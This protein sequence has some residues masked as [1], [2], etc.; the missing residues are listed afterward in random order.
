MSIYSQIPTRW[1][2]TAGCRRE[3][4]G[5]CYHSVQVMDPE[6]MISTAHGRQG[7][8][9]RTGIVAGS[10]ASWRIFLTV[11]DM[12]LALCK[13]QVA[14]RL[15]HPSAAHHAPPGGHLCHTQMRKTGSLHMGLRP[16]RKSRKATRR[17]SLSWREEAENGMTGLRHRKLQEQP[18]RRGMVSLAECHNDRRLIEGLTPSNHSILTFLDAYLGRPRRPMSMIKR[19]PSATS[20]AIWSRLCSGGQ[21]ASCRSMNWRALPRGA[22][23]RRR[24]W[25]PGWTSSRPQQRDT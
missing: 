9:A 1:R 11:Q 17:R 3:M 6:P 19:T 12:H 4:V 2:F 15:P 5:L 21:S 13:L 22:S 8:C 20:R 16:V 18:I 23:S 24:E 7:Q 10:Q 14:I 25:M